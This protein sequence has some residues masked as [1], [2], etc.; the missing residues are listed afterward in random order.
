M[1]RENKKVKTDYR[2]HC[3]YA[4]LLRVQKHTHTTGEIVSVFLLH[5]IESGGASGQKL[6]AL[7]KK[8]VEKET[9]RKRLSDTVFTR[10]WLKEKRKIQ[11]IYS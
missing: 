4:Q 1:N 10:F 2:R 11:R 7:R 9:R 6:G 5:D 8:G 3:K